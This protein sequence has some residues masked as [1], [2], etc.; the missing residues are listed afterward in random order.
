MKTHHNCLRCVARP[1]KRVLIL[2]EG[3]EGKNCRCFKRDWMSLPVESCGKFPSVF[4]V[5][6]S[7]QSRCVWQ[8]SEINSFAI[9]K[10]KGTSVASLVQVHQTTMKHALLMR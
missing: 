2:Q 10:S 1:R 9:V 4:L 6:V 3:E 5:T 8:M 7:F